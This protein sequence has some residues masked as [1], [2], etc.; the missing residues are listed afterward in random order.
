[1]TALSSTELGL[2]ELGS[3]VAIVV[4]VV[5][6]VRHQRKKSQR[7]Q[8]RLDQ[9]KSDKHIPALLLAIAVGAT[10]AG[11]AADAGAADD[12]AEKTGDGGRF[13]RHSSSQFRVELTPEES[14][15]YQQARDRV[16]HNVSVTTA[17]QACQQVL[18]KM[19]YGKPEVDPEFQF[20]EA[21]KNESLIDTS[22]QILR[23]IWKMKLP[24]SG[25]P[26]HQTTEARIT[27]QAD[28]RSGDVRVR[29]RFRNTV[30]DSNGDARSKIASESQTYQDFFSQ[31]ES[32]LPQFR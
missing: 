19:G 22:R 6:S 4:A 8:R 25:K 27:L 30:W 17:M 18:E 13:L 24:L 21:E 31:V 9:G 15:R 10:L 32:N 16:L 14:A 12:N 28:N 2:L 29:V 11:L 7:L 20:L 23:A 26:D 1:M 3:I 5:L